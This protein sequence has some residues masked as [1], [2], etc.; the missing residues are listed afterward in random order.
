M[1]RYSLAF[2]LA[3]IATPALAQEAGPLDVFG[4]TEA[5]IAVLIPFLVSAWKYYQQRLPEWVASLLP[6]VLALVYEYA[7][8]WAVTAEGT[9]AGLFIAG[10]ATL[11]RQVSVKSARAIKAPTPERATPIKRR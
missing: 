10:L 2:C 5:L 7:S 1:N 6:L 11:L 8:A 3:L 4:L 9:V